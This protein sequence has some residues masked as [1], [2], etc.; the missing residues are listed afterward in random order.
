[1]QQVGDGAAD[2]R[3]GEGSAGDGIGAAVDRRQH[4]DARRRDEDV[5]PAIGLR[6]QPVVGVGRGHGDDARIGGRIAVGRLRTV[7]A[8]RRDQHQ[9][10]RAGAGAGRFQQIVVRSDEAHVDDAHLLAGSPVERV[11]DDVHGRLAALEGARMVD[12]GARR[13]A[14]KR[15]DAGDQAGDRGAVVAV[16]TWR[17]RAWRRI[18]RRSRRRAP[19][20]SRRSRCR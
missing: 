11:E 18:R 17:R 10:A 3:G 14:A 2:D 15:A 8:G 6:H 9:A 4:V 1:M 19:D 20:G 13:H 7:V 16:V 5:G 12:G